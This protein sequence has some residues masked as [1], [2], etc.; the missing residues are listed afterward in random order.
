MIH[1]M[2]GIRPVWRFTALSALL[3][4]TIGC[5][6][7]PPSRTVEP[8]AVAGTSD[9]Q[10]LVQLAQN[11]L[12]TPYRYGGISPRTGFDCSGLVYY[13]H[14]ML[15]YTL[16]RTSSAQYHA[17]QRV[18][19]TKLLPGDLVFFKINRSKISHVGIYLGDG[20]FIHSPSSGK[21]VSVGSLEDPYWKKRFIGG[22]RI[23]F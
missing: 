21:V 9:H 19:R 10:R 8:A 17:S 15:G 16:P 23:F 6:S 3:W 18:P 22:G 5:S 13:T 1:M 7:T 12:G 14:K 20:Q 2:T 4:L 11:M